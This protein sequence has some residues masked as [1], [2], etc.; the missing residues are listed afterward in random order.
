VQYELHLRS[1]ALANKFIDCQWNGASAAVS[2]YS[3]FQFAIKNEGY[4][5]ALIR[6]TFE[7]QSMTASDYV[8]TTS[9]QLFIEHPQRSLAYKFEYSGS[10][11]FRRDGVCVTPLPSEASGTTAQRPS[12]GPQTNPWPYLDT[13]VGRTIWWDGDSFEDYIGS[14][15]G[16]GGVTDGDKGDITVS[17]SG[18][19][20][21]IDNNA[22]TNAKL[23]DDA[24]GIAELSATGTADGTTFL[25][26]DNVWATPSGSGTGISNVVD[27]AT[28]QL[29]GNLD[30]N[31][32]TVGDATAADLTKLH[33][34]TA[35]STELN[36]VDGVTSAIQTQLDGKASA[37]RTITAGTGLTGGGDLSADRTLSVTYGTTSGT[38]CQGGDSRLSDTRT[39]TDGTVTTA[40]FAASS[41]TTSSE[42]I[43]SND[44]DT[45]VPTTAA[46]KKY[47]DIVNVDLKTAN[48]TLAASD[49]GK[50]IGMNVASANTITLPSN[51]T[52]AITLGAVIPL[53]QYGTGQTTIVAGS[54]ATVRAP[55]G[56]LKFSGQYSQAVAWKVNTNEWMVSGDLTS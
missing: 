8:L 28:P 21:T 45:Q 36:Y 19:T 9:N 20:W 16:G 30:L 56:K 10:G 50:G 52:A 18:S 23:A 54:G 27:D 14:G 15:G 33:A 47:A 22:V 26:G 6:P 51:T 25:R 40:K 39:P 43:E 34:L 44:S 11:D 32:F 4:R 42:T 17:S 7:F 13:T 35:T 3:A 29:G 2:G 41:L 24:V 12:Y 49:R 38:A 55:G 53:F 48:Y 37:S 5:N 46:V 1:N 31:T